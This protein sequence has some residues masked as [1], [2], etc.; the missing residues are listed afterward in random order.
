M[1]F[2]AVHESAIWHKADIGLRGL[3]SAFGG[4][5]EIDRNLSLC[6]LLTQSGHR[7]PGP[8]RPNLPRRHFQMRWPMTPAIAKCRTHSFRQSLR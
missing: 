7:R 5:A 4:E 2:A 1:L 8:T 6:L 3:N